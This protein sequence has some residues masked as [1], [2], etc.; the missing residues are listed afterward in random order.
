MAGYQLKI[1]EKR[2]SDRKKLTGLMPGRF[3]I[4]DADASARPIDISAHGL[5]ILVAKEYK[6]GS[7]ATLIL[8]EN[9]IKFE[10]MWSQPDFGKQ[11]LW[12]YGLVCKDQ[13]INIEGLFEANG[14]FK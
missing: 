4:S 7:I 2:I 13:N 6:V 5:G 8:K 11:D 14:C 3:Q 10:I 12:R 9:V 1:K